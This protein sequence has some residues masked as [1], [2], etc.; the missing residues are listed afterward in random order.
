MPYDPSQ[1]FRNP[2][3][4]QV[5]P[6]LDIPDDSYV[7]PIKPI[8]AEWQNIQDAFLPLG[9]SA[10]TQLVITGQPFMRLFPMSGS[11][12]SNDGE[13]PRYESAGV[14]TRF[15]P[16]Q[17]RRRWGVQLA[18]TRAGVLAA[19]EHVANLSAFGSATGQT[20][21]VVLDFCWVETIDYYACLIAGLQPFTV[22]LGLIS[23]VNNPGPGAGYAG[24]EQFRATGGQASFTFVERDLRRV[25]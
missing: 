11:T 4:V 23:E 3:L 6:G 5:V 21:L 12:R 20:P 22:R 10:A 1:A 25:I 13:G 7:P 24:F 8:D 17:V 2:W 18:E 9:V 14:G 15:V 19:L 16:G